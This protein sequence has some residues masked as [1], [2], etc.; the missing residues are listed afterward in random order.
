MCDVE[1]LINTI[2][3]PAVMLMGLSQKENSTAP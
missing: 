2:D 1:E 3:E